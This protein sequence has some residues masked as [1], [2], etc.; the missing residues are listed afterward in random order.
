MD[1][2]KSVHRFSF[3]RGDDIY[4]VTT[5]EGLLTVTCKV[6]FKEWKELKVVNKVIS[7]EVTPVLSDNK[8]D[9]LTIT[10]MFIKKRKGTEDVE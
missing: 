8:D 5:V 3:D 4:L 7:E 9:H 1:F 2:F 10:N 6:D